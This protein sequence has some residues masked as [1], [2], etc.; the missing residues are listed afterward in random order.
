MTET[1]WAQG[2]SDV[3]IAKQLSEA[4]NFYGKNW[5]KIA[6]DCGYYDHA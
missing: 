6:A 4:R 5:A 2:R 1:D 3:I